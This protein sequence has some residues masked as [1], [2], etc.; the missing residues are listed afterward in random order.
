MSSS[1][2]IEIGEAL[3]TMRITIDVGRGGGGG[4]VI[5]FT[6]ILLGNWI[7]HHFIFSSLYQSPPVPVPEP[8]PS[9]L[10]SPTPF[11]AQSPGPSPVQVLAP[12]F[13]SPPVPAFGTMRITIEVG[14][15]ITSVLRLH[16]Y[17]IALCII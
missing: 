3:G 5:G 13:F 6:F 11:E 7:M 1:E 4:V 10:H 15:D 16:Y 17:E 2:C 14:G 9:L 8:L 12:S